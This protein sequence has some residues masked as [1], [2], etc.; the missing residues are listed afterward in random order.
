M[1]HSYDGSYGH[2]LVD[3]GWYIYTRNHDCGKQTNN[4]FA[5]NEGWAEFWAE[6]WAGD[7]YSKLYVRT[8]SK[9]KLQI[10]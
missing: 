1:R 7:C 10:G 2:F 8:Y 6:F 3:V 4:G 5:F 9:L